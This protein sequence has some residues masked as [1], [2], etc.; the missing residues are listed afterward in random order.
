MANNK[1]QKVVQVGMFCRV[2]DSNFAEHGVKKNDIVYIAGDSYVPI[3]EDDPY[4]FRRIF[5]AAWMNGDVV[6]VNRGGF[7]IDGVRLK[8]VSKA[9]QEKLEAILNEEFGDADET[10][11]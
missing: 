5:V 3:S 7:T 9:K 1:K 6:D 4:S 11:D 10:T 8:P 2:Q